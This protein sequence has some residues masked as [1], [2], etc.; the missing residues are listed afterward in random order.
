MEITFINH[1]SCLIKYK[2]K[3]II[4]DPIWSNWLGVPLIFG[5]K[6]QKEP[7]L[8]FEDIL[9]IDI[10]LISHNHFDH[11]DIPSLLDSEH[12]DHFCKYCI[13]IGKSMSPVCIECEKE[14]NYNFKEDAEI[15]I[16]KKAKD[17][18]K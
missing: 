3:Y 10:V 15:I 7:G 13:N 1:S 5:R 8:K 18:W 17:L 16:M 14:G 4:T 11:M 2:G 6:R 9:Q 12:A